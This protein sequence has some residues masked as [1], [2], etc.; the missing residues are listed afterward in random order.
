M[1]YMRKQISQI[2]AERTGTRKLDCLILAPP[3]RS[4]WKQLSIEVSSTRRAMLLVS[5]LVSSGIRGVQLSDGRTFTADKVLLCAGAWTS[6]LMSSVE[7]HLQMDDQ[8]RFERQAVAAGY[9]VAH[10]ALGEQDVVDLEAMPVSVYGH[11]GDIQ[12]S[13]HGNLLKVTNYRS[14]TNTIVTES[15]H[16]MTVP[17]DRDHKVVPRSLKAE[18]KAIIYDKLFP[19]LTSRAG[20][21]WRLCWDAMTPSQDHVITKHPDP[22][23]DN[24]YLAVGGSFHS[25]KFLPNIG[26]YVVNVLTGISN[27]PEHDRR[28]AWKLPDQT[29]CEIHA[30]VYPSRE[31]CDL[32]NEHDFEGEHNLEDEREAVAAPVASQTDQ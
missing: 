4:S 32:E 22:R 26:K 18:N 6:S 25:C 30:A 11:M 14:V 21:Y 13:P 31:L 29:V 27:G 15:A 2:R 9:S 17:P 7:D 10:Y 23:L 24:L 16:K 19:Q 20:V 12:P 1:V 5:C 3:R 28:W 8:S